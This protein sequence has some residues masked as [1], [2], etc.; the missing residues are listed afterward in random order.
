VNRDFRIGPWLVQPSLNTVSQNGAS[1]RLEPKVMEVLVCLAEHTGEVVPKET[2]LQASSS[3]LE[4]RMAVHD[5][6]R[7]YTTTQCRLL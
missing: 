7:S 6:R 3:R 5:S 1:T 2:L 4:G